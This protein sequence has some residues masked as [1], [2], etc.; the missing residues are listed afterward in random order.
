MSQVCVC[1]CVHARIFYFMQYVQ[2]FCKYP[3]LPVCL[4]F[5]VV[6]L[7]AMDVVH[8][9]KPQNQ[10]NSQIHMFTKMNLMF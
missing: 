1:V 10:S 8:L 7:R 3:S 6:K 4:K 2:A 5:V 9:T